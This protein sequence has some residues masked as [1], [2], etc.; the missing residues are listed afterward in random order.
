MIGGLKGF[1]EA[2][3]IRP[4]IYQL[5]TFNYCGSDQ[6]FHSLQNITLF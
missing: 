3:V 2:S 5:S 6:N 4:R 1:F